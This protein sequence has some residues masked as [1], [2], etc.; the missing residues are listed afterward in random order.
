MKA[1]TI[2]KSLD[3]WFQDCE[4]LAPDNPIN[5]DHLGEE[6]EQ[7]SIEVVPC[8]PIIKRYSDGSAKMQYLFIFASRNHYG[9]DKMLNIENLDFPYLEPGAN[10]ISSTEDCRLTVIY[11]PIF[12]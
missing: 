5:V 2:I 9:E 7:Y 8:S 10:V 6:P 4:V 11:T 12:V 1:S 3:N